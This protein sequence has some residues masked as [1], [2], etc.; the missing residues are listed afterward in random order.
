MTAL[1]RIADKFRVLNE[2]LK[3][4][5]Q[6]GWTLAPGF[7]LAQPL[8]ESAI[9]EIE[10]RYGVTLPAEYRA[11]LKRFGDGTVGPGNVFF[12]FRDAVT[13]GARQPFPLSRPFLGLESPELRGLPE[14][15]RWQAYGPLLKEWEAIPQNHGAIRICDYGCGMQGVLIVNGPFCGKVWMLS[16]D[17]AYYGPFGG[18]ECLHDETAPNDEPTETPRDY[19]FLEWYENWLDGQLKMTGL[20]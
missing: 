2:R 20:V 7:V 18:A 10:R 15:G 13:E 1:D 6:P 11:F 16:G 9:Q 19:S 8:A 5:A 4:H 14:Q 17:A 12:R 3:D